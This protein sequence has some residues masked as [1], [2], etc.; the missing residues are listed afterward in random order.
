M[1]TITHNR[2]HHIRHLT[3]I[4]NRQVPHPEPTSPNRII[5]TTTYEPTQCNNNRRHLTHNRH[6]TI[7]L[8]NH[9]LKHARRNHTTLRH[10]HTHDRHHTTIQHLRSP[11]HYSRQRPRQSRSHR[12]IRH[13]RRLINLIKIGST[14]VPTHL[15]TLN[16]SNIRTYIHSHPHLDQTNNN[17]NRRHTNHTRH[18]SLIKTQRTRIGTSRPKAHHSRHHRRNIILQGTSMSL[19]RHNKKPHTRSHRVKNRTIRP[20]H[21]TH[22]VTSEKTITRRISTPHTINRHN[23]INRHLRH[24]HNNRH[25]RPRVPRPTHI[26]RYH[27]RN[28]NQN[29]YRQ[30][31]RR[32]TTRIRNNS[33][34]NR[35][36]LYN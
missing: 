10:G 7:K 3:H 1:S 31:L 34:I 30:N 5:S 27:N 13:I 29:S 25:P 26:Q 35:N 12:R 20:H 16:R 8:Q 33:R 18:H 28:K 36:V 14:T 9:H 17:H 4:V 24:L 6:I 23:N 15:P 32:Q 21:F 2:H 22:Q 11:A 19:T